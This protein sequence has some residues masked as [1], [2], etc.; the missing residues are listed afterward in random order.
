MKGYMVYKTE[1]CLDDSEDVKC[2]LDFEKGKAFVEEMN[3]PREEEMKLLRQCEECANNG[4]G[5]ET[6]YVLR[7]T[8]SRC[9]IA[10]DRHG[11]YCEN[12]I[13][14]FYKLTT[15]QYYVRGVDVE[16][17]DKSNC[18]NNVVKV[19][20]ADK[21]VET[22]LKDVVNLLDMACYCDGVRRVKE[23]TARV[24]TLLALIDFE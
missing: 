5:E 4:Y 14:S 19:R 11:V 21:A 3:K 24:K 23:A 22:I 9:K 12:E 1:P 18:S 8:C 7:D 13:D 10:K 20:Y 16:D 17:I 15:A 2:F 6:K